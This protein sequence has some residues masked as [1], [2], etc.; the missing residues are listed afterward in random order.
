MIE[1]YRK[2]RRRMTGSEKLMNVSVKKITWHMIDKK[3]ASLN[4]PSLTVTPCIARDRCTVQK[5]RRI[6]TT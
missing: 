3:T 4:L 5:L 6:V 1:R 2:S